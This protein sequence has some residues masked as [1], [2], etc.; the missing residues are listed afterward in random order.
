[1]KVIGGV[2]DGQYKAI[3]SG[4]LPNGKPV[5]VNADGTVS[6]VAEQSIT[7]A[8]GTEATFE[9]GA[10]THIQG[11]YDSGSSRV[12]IVYNQGNTEGKLI[13]GEVSGTTISF[14]TPA[15]FDTDSVTWTDIAY[16]PVAGK[17][18][19]TF[20]DE[21]DGWGKARVATVNPLSNSITLGP[22]PY[23]FETVSTYYTSCAYDSNAGKFLIAWRGAN[24]YGRAVV[25]TVS[26]NAIS[27]GTEAVFNSGSSNYIRVKYDST[28]NQMMIVYMDGGNSNRGTAIIGE[29]SGTSVSFGSEAVFESG[30]SGTLYPDLTWVPENNCWV[31]AWNSSSDANKGTAIIA[32]VSGTA[33]TYGTEAEFTTTNIGRLSV[34]YHEAAKKAFIAWGE[35]ASPYE[36]YIVPCNISGTTLT[37]GTNVTYEASNAQYP[38]TIYD[39]DTDQIVVVWQDITADDGK[40]I[41]YTPTYT[42]A[43]LTAENYIGMSRGVVLPKTIGDEVTYASTAVYSATA[44]DTANNKFVIAYRNNSNSNYGTAI[45]G[46]VNGATITFGSPAVFESAESNDIGIAYDANAGKFLIT[47][48]DNGNSGFGT[49]VVA[50]VSGTSISFGTPVVFESASTSYNLPIYDAN[51]QKVVNFYGDVDN[52]GSPTAIVATISGTSVS[53]GTPVTAYSGACYNYGAAYDST[54]QKIVFAFRASAA[55][56]GIARVATVSGTSISFGTST[57]FTSNVITETTAVYDANADKTVIAYRDNSASNVGKAIVGTMSGTS[58]SFG[59]EVTFN[60]ASTDETASTYNSDNGTVIIAYKDQGNSDY[61]TYVIGT[62]SGTSISFGSEVVFA[63]EAVRPQ[64]QSVFYDPDQQRTIFPYRKDADASG[65][66]KSIDAVPNPATAETTNGNPARVDIIGSV[67]DNQLSL[68]AGEKYYVQTDG[69][70]STTAG[71]PSV[72]AGT[73]ISATKLVVKT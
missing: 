14:G 30:V 50:T 40:A 56:Q 10:A 68:T 47:Y 67:S 49:A 15:T 9:S 11:T 57:V 51:A 37:F 33:I 66:V 28:N 20:R 6:A 1:M 62:V 41:T 19:F 31:I 44:Y 58:I 69:T 34:V 7:E 2:P 38:D 59:T 36:G 25:A 4:T 48:R 32:T 72:L 26:G 61:G 3:A 43:N 53:F 64:A 5:V 24:N 17:V 45:V 13:V 55:A 65:N 73:A 60:N 22:S 35:A 29:I 18:L 46:T 27:F 16:D 12:V 39:S 71:S 70:L 21:G 23:T 52:S 42:V 63:Q 54:S 8:T